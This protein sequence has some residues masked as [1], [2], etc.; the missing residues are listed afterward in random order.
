MRIFGPALSG[1]FEPGF[2]PRPRLARRREAALRFAQ[3]FVRLAQRVRGLSKL[4]GGGLA[5]RLRLADFIQNFVAAVRD[6]GRQIAKRRQLGLDAGEP[7]VQARDL[8][9]RA[10]GALQPAQAL[11]AD[12]LEPELP[13]ANVAVDAIQ[14]G[15]GFGIDIALGARFV[16]ELGEFGFSLIN[17]RAAASASWA[18]SRAASASSRP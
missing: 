13:P 14:R 1:G 10:F 6:L 7:I 2:H 5:R 3:R 12:C 16:L 15:L 8:R 11:L 4:I 9:I 18:V 17:G